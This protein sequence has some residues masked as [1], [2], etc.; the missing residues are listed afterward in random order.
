[1]PV[2][3]W[4]I[5]LHL[6]FMGFLPTVILKSRL[7]SISIPVASAFISMP[8]MA[9]STALITFEA[10]TAT[11]GTPTSFTL[12]I[13]SNILS[14]HSFSEVFIVTKIF[15]NRWSVYRCKSLVR[16]R[17]HSDPIVIV[18]IIVPVIMIRIYVHALHHLLE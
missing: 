3:L 11:T 8:H 10:Y 18:D 4:E 7:L 1:M 17:P 2:E 15:I 5:N 16:N 14:E 12:S 9:S 13:Y 6:V